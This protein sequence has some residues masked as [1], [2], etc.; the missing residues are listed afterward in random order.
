MISTRD[1]SALPEG[2]QLK[3]LMQSMATLDAILNREWDG[4]YY[5]FNNKWSADE[6]MG[7]MRDGSGDEFFC[8][9]NSEGAILKGFGHEM[10]MTTF[11]AQPPKIWPGIYD[12]V[13]FEFAAFLKEPA[14]SISDVTFCIWRL[15][16][17]LVWHCGKIDFPSGKDPDGSADL[18]KMLD[19]NPETYHGWAEEYYEREVNRSAVEKFYAHSPLTAPLVKLLNRD[20]TLKEIQEDIDEIGYPVQK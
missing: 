1:L 6:S 19:G 17:D 2:A 7:S 3:R 8:L 14:F 13:P 12:S 16:T 4:R 5:S 20:V 9:F 15:N 18:L 10:G 11:R